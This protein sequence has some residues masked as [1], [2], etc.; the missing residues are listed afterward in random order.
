MYCCGSFRN[1]VEMAGERGFAILVEETTSLGLVFVFQSRGV[2]HG[3]ESK[4]GP[5]SGDMLINIASSTGFRFCPWCGEEAQLMIDKSPKEFQKLAQKH[6][7]LK[8][9]DL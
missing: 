1:Y 2:D 3:D 8:T 6:K 7:K 5:T 9:L 4:L